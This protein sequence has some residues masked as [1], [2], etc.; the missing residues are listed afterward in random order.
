[1]IFCGRSVDD[2]SLTYLPL[3]IISIWTVR[4]A[5]SVYVVGTEDCR[6][7]GAEDHT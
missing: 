2:G 5:V 6:T 1:M 4:N 3:L 7:F